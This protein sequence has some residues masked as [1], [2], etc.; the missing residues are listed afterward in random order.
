[1]SADVG[2]AAPDFELPA[3][4]GRTVR[5]RE[6]LE[7]GPV[8]LLFFPLAYSEVCTRELCAVRDEWSR[9]RESGAAVLAI[10]VDSPFVTERLRE[11]HD[12]PFPVLSDFNREVIGRYGVVDP[13]LH[14]LREVAIRSAFVVDRDGRIAYRW[15]AD[16]PGEEPPYDEVLDAVGEVG[17][18]GG[19]TTTGRE[20]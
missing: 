7:D 19:V 6:P 17:G 16:E 2:E 5:L 9:W 14:G 4:P 18:A 15:T 13:D 10:S 8:V 12:L 20:R 3:A 1:M 11:E